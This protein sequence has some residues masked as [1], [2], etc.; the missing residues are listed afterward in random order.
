MKKHTHK[1]PNR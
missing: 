1:H